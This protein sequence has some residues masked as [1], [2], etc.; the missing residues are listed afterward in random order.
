[1]E[2]WL[3]SIARCGEMTGFDESMAAR[4]VIAAHASLGRQVQPFLEFDLLTQLTTGQ[5]YTRKCC[6]D[7]VRA[8]RGSMRVLVLRLRAAA[9]AEA[10]KP[11]VSVLVGP[12]PSSLREQGD[13]L[14]FIVNT[15]TNAAPLA[16]SQIAEMQAA[17]GVLVDASERQVMAALSVSSILHHAMARA[18]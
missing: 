1:V 7:I 16:A 13:E 8:L 3:F 2:V 11:R 12:T 15:Y 4:A 6:A 10:H 9:V 14:A 17:C 5:A 18:Q